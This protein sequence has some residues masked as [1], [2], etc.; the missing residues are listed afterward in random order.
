MEVSLFY[1]S[2]DAGRN[3]VALHDAAENVD[4]NSFN[5]GIAENDFKRGRYLFLACV[6]AH[7]EEVG[8]TSA[9]MLNDVHGRHGQ[10]SAID[11]ASDCSIVLGEVE[12]EFTGPGLQ[13]SFPSRI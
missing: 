12:I 13:R 3:D 10:P 7:I 6:T 8:R 5:V 11:E 4:E 1:R 9:V 2:D